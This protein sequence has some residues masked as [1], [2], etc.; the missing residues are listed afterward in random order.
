M[1]MLDKME[2]YHAPVG[3]YQN[4]AGLETT[5]FEYVYPA[6]SLA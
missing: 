4:S 6:I 2:D 1:S 5:H 3:I